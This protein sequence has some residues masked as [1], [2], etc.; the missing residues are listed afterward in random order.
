MT[1]DFI[2]HGE[3][4]KEEKPLTK[5]QEEEKEKLR[6]Q[7]IEAEKKKLA[8]KNAEIKE[9]GKLQRNDNCRCG[10]GKKFKNCCINTWRKKLNK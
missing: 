2:I 7:E 3:Q 10:S 6:Q 4:A 5:E 9:W 8:E 1:G